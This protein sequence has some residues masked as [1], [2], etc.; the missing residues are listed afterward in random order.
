[1][2]VKVKGNLLQIS[3]PL[4]S[5]SDTNC[6]HVSV[7]ML[8]VCFCNKAHI[9]FIR[10]FRIKSYLTTWK[11]Y[12]NFETLVRIHFYGRRWNSKC[13]LICFTLIHISKMLDR[14]YEYSHFHPTWTCIQVSC[15]K[16]SNQSMG[17]C[18]IG[19]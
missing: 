17:R 7:A 16:W 5:R 11:H 1:M 15:T 2:R 8:D 10:I 6:V 19:N 12:N 13:S 18:L 3:E 9:D 4:R 14:W